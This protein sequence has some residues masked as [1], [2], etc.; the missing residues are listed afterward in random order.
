MNSKKYVLS[1]EA[2]FDLD[3]IFDY[4]S[5]EFGFNQAIDYLSELEMLFDKLAKTPTIGKARNEIKIG[6]FSFPM[7]SH[8]I[9]YRVMGNHIRIVRVLYGGKD[10]VKN[11]GEG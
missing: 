10:L 8:I 11:F 4:T 1:E 9:F 7:R 3:S 5:T 6:L 2:D